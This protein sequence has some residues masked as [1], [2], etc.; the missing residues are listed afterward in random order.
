VGALGGPI[1]AGVGAVIGGGAGAV[2]GATTSP[3]D[4]NLGRPPWNNPDTRVPTP[5]GP[6]GPQTSAG[7]SRS[8]DGY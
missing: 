8:S 6:V 7:S 5:D 2:T 1:G 3:K 4:V